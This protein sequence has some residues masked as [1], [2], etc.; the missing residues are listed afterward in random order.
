MHG[1][2]RWGWALCAVG[3]LATS[4]CRDCVPPTG[5]PDAGRQVQE[6]PKGPRRV[7]VRV[8]S[9]L[10]DLPEV[11]WRAYAHRRFYEVSFV[12]AGD[13][14]EPIGRLP[15][16]DGVDP[17]RKGVG[18]EL[19]RVCR[20]DTFYV[21]LPR[22][23]PVDN[24]G[25]DPTLPTPPA[26]FAQ[27]LGEEL[28]RWVHRERRYE[29]LFGRATDL[30]NDPSGTPAPLPGMCGANAARSPRLWVREAVLCDAVQA[31]RDAAIKAYG[32]T[33]QTKHSEGSLAKL[34]HVGRICSFGPQGVEEQACSKAPVL[35]WHL[36]RIGLR[37]PSLGPGDETV[38]LA[39]IDSGLEPGYGGVGLDAEEVA[40]CDAYAGE[41]F[42]V[43]GTQMALLARQ[44]V[45]DPRVKLRSYRIFSAHGESTPNHL[46]RAL[47]MALYGPPASP[48]VVA[49]PPTGKTPPAT[50]APRHPLVV[51]LS[52]GW[53]PELGQARVLTGWRGQRGHGGALSW[54]QCTTTED[55][56]GAPVDYLLRTTKLLNEQVR[57][58][59]VVAAAGNRPDVHSDGRKSSRFAEGFGVARRGSGAGDARDGRDRPLWFYPAQFARDR[60]PRGIQPLAVGAVNDRDEPTAVS[61]PS[62]EP[63][64]V[65]PGQHVYAQALSAGQCPTGPLPSDACA[66]HPT[67]NG[68]ACPGLHLPSAITGTSVATVLVSASAARA[69]L[70]RLSHG[71]RP[72][73]GPRLARLL[74]LGGKPVGKLTPPPSA[75]AAPLPLW[76]GSV[77]GSPVRRLSVAGVDGLLSD[78]AALDARI[79]PSLSHPPLATPGPSVP[80]RAGWQPP[81]PV[82]WTPTYTPTSTTASLATAPAAWV[83]ASTATTMPWKDFYS[84]AG[85]GPQPPEGPCP[86]C[87]VWGAEGLSGSKWTTISAAL[88]LDD[89]V[90]GTQYLSAKVI[91]YAGG[92]TWSHALDPTLL[93]PGATIVHTLPAKVFPGSLKTATAKLVVVTGSSPATGISSTAPLRVQPQ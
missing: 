58:V 14:L 82:W 91:I 11:P 22:L 25:D 8:D 34:M 28:S 66:Q 65:A 86:E 15:A 9:V 83:D 70:Y 41:R 24:E 50:G 67:L 38:E 87:C 43:H 89:P 88:E 46:A 13:D 63:A 12:P 6:D 81:D 85:L 78:P 61:I 74:Y 27:R 55:P 21:D 7:E 2:P 49:A 62:A 44:V 26:A 52:V 77:V 31:V 53:P 29:W 37:A 57:P 3:L 23:A 1:I 79:P 35:Q 93:K 19:L 64:L 5:S 51:N 72:L 59:L 84:V 69:Q 40:A 36:G 73:V 4:G 60:A 76:R 54:Q 47:D 45:A 92:Q 30:T 48:S 80:P 75:G 32:A 71:Q 90:P 39:L 10:P 20:P 42:H 16:A 18:P 33:V 56:V 17:E 68:C